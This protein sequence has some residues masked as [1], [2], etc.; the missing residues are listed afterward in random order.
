MAAIQRWPLYTVT[1]NIS[2]SVLETS[3]DLTYVVADSQ[4]G[5]VLLCSTVTIGGKGFPNPL[6]SPS[7]YTPPSLFRALILPLLRN[8]S[9]YSPDCLSS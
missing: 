4:S 2:G 9:P 6:T 3:F 8:V 7:P 1:S 5:V